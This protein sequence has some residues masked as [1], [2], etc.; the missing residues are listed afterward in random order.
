MQEA[1]SSL[2]G[3]ASIPSRAGRGGR[4]CVCG[5]QATLL[6]AA[7]LGHSSRP[8]TQPRPGT[9]LYLGINHSR[10]EGPKILCRL[11]ARETWM[12][13]RWPPA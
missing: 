10:E 5:S 7:D 8:P 11:E 12:E 3:E 13:W 2:G 9:P 6:K 1:R 4:G